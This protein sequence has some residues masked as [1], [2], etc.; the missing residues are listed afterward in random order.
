[1]KISY[2][3]ASILI[4]LAMIALKMLAL[5]SLLYRHA[6]S[7][8]IF[9]S[10]ILM[11]I[12][13]IYAYIIIGLIEKSGH[14]NSYEFMKYCIGTVGAK[15]VMIVLMLMFALVL[16]NLSKGLEFFVVENLYNELNWVVFVL[17]LMILVSFMV[18]KGIRNIGRVGEI[19]CWFIIFGIIFIGLKSVSGIELDSF[20][21]LF[22]EGVKP[23]FEAAFHHMAWFGSSTFLLMFFG[24]VDFQDKKKSRLIMY[25]ILSILIVHFMIVIFYGLFQVTSPTHNYMLSDISQFSTNQASI[26]ELSWLVVALWIVAQVIQLAI[27]SYSFTQ[28]I[29][30]IFNIHNNTIPIAIVSIYIAVWSILGEN[31]INLERIFFTPIASAITIIAQYIIP[32]IILISFYVKKKKKPKLNK[33]VKREEVENLV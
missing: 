2:R 27:Y 28:T 22:P 1:M 33:E 23:L 13:A 3:Q 9:V 26:D 19:F 11:T 12:D 21:P 7:S 17:P 5:P 15:I 20:L 30:F 18:Y 14:K 8:A 25:L 32:I 10:L 29:K 4:F 31:T 6:G 24:K 16:A